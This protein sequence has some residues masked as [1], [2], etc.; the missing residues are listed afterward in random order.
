MA[1]SLGW[2]RAYL[3]KLSLVARWRVA[4]PFGSLRVSMGRHHGW[5]ARVRFIRSL[6]LCP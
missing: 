6:G 5:L 3:A 2:N 1:F 4:A